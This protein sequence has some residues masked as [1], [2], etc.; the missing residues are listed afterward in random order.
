[1]LIFTNKSENKNY[2]FIHIPKNSGKYIRNKI[3]NDKNNAISKVYWDIA[4]NLDLAHI[5]YILKD[6]FIE[7][8]VEYN[9]FT[10]TRCP[11]NRI[12]SAFFYKNPRGNI[13]T[14]RWFVK[15]TLISYNFSMDYN[16]DI[17][18]Y[19]PQY[20]FVCDETFN[21]PTNIKIDK[22]E[23]VENPR[24]YNLI[25]YFD[26]SCIDIINNIYRKDFLYF[27]YLMIDSI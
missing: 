12:I 14:F 11:Y 15:N 20:L 13:D 17:I 23:D 6:K 27:N 25:Q 21:I 4:F 24:K 9:Y 1:M 7:N 10:Y 16:Y 8:N 5:P 26:S 19:Y 18:H 2:I 22:L 3:I